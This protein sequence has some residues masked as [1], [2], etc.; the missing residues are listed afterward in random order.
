LWLD[1][2]GGPGWDGVVMTPPR[3]L[4]PPGTE[5]SFHHCIS[6]FVDRRFLFGPKEK[7]V[8]LGLL[9]KYERLCGVRVLTYCIMDNHFDSQATAA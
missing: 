9:R 4:A 5:V 7:K 2:G 8:F 3:L 1:L 6:R